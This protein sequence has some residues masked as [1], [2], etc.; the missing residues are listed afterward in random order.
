MQ[1]ALAFD[2]RGHAVVKLTL[3]VLFVALLAGLAIADDTNQPPQGSLAYLDWHYGFRDLKFEQSI[4]TCKGMQ[5]IEDDGEMKF[6]HRKSDRLELGGAKLKLIEYGFYKG[7]FATVVITAAGVPDATTMLKSLEMDFG[8]AQK[9][10]RNS[11]KL[12][13]FG[14][15]VLVDYMTSPTGPPSVGMWSRPLQARQ[16]AEK[17]PKSVDK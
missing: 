8:P 12:Y 3:A 5:L 4:S 6:Y 11:H 13:W 7:K 16:L 15:K 1:G 2:P 10:P 17:Q 14:K 9:S